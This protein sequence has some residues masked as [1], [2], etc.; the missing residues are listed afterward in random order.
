[1]KKTIA[2]MIAG[3]S[4]ALCGCKSSLY[5]GDDVAT[6]LALCRAEFVFDYEE[7]ILSTKTTE[8]DGFIIVDVFGESIHAKYICRDGKVMDF[9]K[10]TEDKK[11]D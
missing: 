3:F 2:M 10:L 11:Y 6:C 8:E 9:E 7:E 1:M 4:L 5:I